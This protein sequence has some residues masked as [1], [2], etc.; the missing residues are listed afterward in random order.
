MLLCGAFS[1]LMITSQASPMAQ[2]MVGMDAS[3]AALVVSTLAVFN[4]LGRLVAGAASDRLGAVG[5]I[6]LV[7][8]SSIAGLVLLSFAGSGHSVPFVAGVCMVGFAFGSIMGIYPGFTASQFGAKNN[9]VNYGIMFI[10]FAV[11]GFFGPTI[12]T[13]LY[14][15]FGSYLPAFFTAMVLAIAGLV[16]TFVFQCQQSHVKTH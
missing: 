14:G 4:T 10:G 5:T 1:G 7:F 13:M 11:A 3:S 2:D 12:M 8:V 9:S 15:A 6:R 16:L